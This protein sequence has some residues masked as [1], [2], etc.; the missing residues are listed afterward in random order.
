M[1]YFVISY[2][3]EGWYHNYIQ[4]EGDS[5]DKTSYLFNID[6]DEEGLHYL[7]VD[8]YDSRMY[9]YEAKKDRIMTDFKIYIWS[10][11]L[12]MYVLL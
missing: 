9:P 2:Y 11:T 7:R 1:L 3:H 10:P 8:H 12:Q 6:N 4:S 5:G